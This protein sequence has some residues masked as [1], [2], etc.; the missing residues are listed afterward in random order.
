M[1]VVNMFITVMQ[2][3]PLLLG[4]FVTCSFVLQNLLT[5]ISSRPEVVF[6]LVSCLSFYVSQIPTSTMIS[7]IFSML[8][9]TQ[10]DISMKLVVASQSELSI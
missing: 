3:L 10:D 7:K 8:N 6:L 4:L 5:K 1:F 2:S 9:T